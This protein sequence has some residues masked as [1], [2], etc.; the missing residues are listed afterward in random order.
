MSS[1]YSVNNAWIAI[2]SSWPAANRQVRASSQH[3]NTKEIRNF[4][5]RVEA[6]GG[7]LR[8]PKLIGPHR[9]LSSSNFD[10]RTAIEILRRLFDCISTESLV[11]GARVLIPPLLVLLFTSIV[12]ANN[13]IRRRVTLFTYLREAPHESL[14]TTNR[15]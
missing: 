13:T 14:M 11:S 1:R 7:V 3:T 2:E 12:S 9:T 10:M 8:R 5:S 15:S 6:D 4:G